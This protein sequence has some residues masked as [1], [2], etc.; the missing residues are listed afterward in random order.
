M[1]HSTAAA[2]RM[3]LVLDGHEVGTVAYRS[4]G[5]PVDIETATSAGL[6]LTDIRRQSAIDVEPFV[7]DAGALRPVLG[8]IDSTL[9]GQHARRSFELQQAGAGQGTSRKAFA[10]L[11]TEVAFPAL[12]R[13]SVDDAF[14]RIKVLPERTE[15]RRTPAARRNAPPMVPLSRHV[16][17]LSI[18]GALD[19]TEAQR[20]EAFTITVGTKRHLAGE[21]PIPHSEPT[22]LAFSN[23][24]FHLAP[25]RAQRLKAWFDAAA[26]ADGPGAATPRKGRLELFSRGGARATSLGLADLDIVSLEGM[27]GASAK[28]VVAC[29]KVSLGSW[30][31]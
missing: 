9:S 11:L 28:V 17:R 3:I 1:G 19:G 16:F 21:S 2:S 10:C 26:A 4:G 18:D 27:N 25:A 24:A 5:Q 6:K 23:L 29:G 30:L 13:R 31:A 14:L 20:V 8:W 7:V 22:N 15:S 12:D